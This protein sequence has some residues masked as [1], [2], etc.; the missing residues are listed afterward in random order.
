MK[1]TNHVQLYASQYLHAS[2]VQ[3]K[4]VPVYY[5]K[6]HGVCRYSTTYAQLWNS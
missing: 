1:H 2:N 5:S 6:V 4:A 3:G